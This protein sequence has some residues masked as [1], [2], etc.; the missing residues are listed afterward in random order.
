MNRGLLAAGGCFL[1]LAVLSPTAAY[2]I[3]NILVPGPGAGLPGDWTTAGGSAVIVCESNGPADDRNSNVVSL[4]GVG[5]LCTTGENDATG[6]GKCVYTA[7]TACP[8]PPAAG[9]E[10]WIRLDTCTVTA[11][12]RTAP[13]A[14]V[15]GTCAAAGGSRATKTW[16]AQLGVFQCDVNAAGVTGNPFTTADEGLYY[17]RLYAWYSYDGD[18]DYTAGD[19]AGA[20]HTGDGD[21]SNVLDN[22][23][24]FHGHVAGF[25][26][27]D[28][29]KN[30]GAGVTGSFEAI[31]VPDPTDPTNTWVTGGGT[32]VMWSGPDVPNPPVPVAGSINGETNDC[33]ASPACVASPVALGGPGTTPAGALCPTPPPVGM[34]ALTGPVVRAF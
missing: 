5:G 24:A 14:A 30:V 7:P 34:L 29:S 4:S 1:L 31:A 23:D 8:A 13:P 11:G 27:T 20:A 32:G 25:I 19:A 26:S 10:A 3:D 18:G 33:G 2:H 22:E 6:W 17:S 9:P 15:A 21:A 12:V 16:T 28:A